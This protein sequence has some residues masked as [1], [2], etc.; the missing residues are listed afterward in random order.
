VS[1]LKRRLLAYLVESP[2]M[3]TVFSAVIPIIAGVLSGTFVFEITT[4]AGLDWNGFYRVH[5][6]Y[7]LC[8]V[9]L[10]I[11][12]YNRKLYLYEREAQRF[13]DDDYCTAY[14]LSKCLP[15]AAERY[16]ELI[17]EGVGGE[18]VQAM[19]ELKKVLKLR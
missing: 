5:S 19:D 13:L 15:E 16:Q 9:S 14:M 18:L 17:R 6:F 4:P 8:V 3:R 1:K 11:Y 7:G 2:A 10:I 12:W